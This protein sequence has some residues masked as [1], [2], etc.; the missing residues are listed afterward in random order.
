MCINI[1][2]NYTRISDSGSIKFSDLF[3]VRTFS[4]RSSLSDS[5][6]FSERFLFLHKFYG[7]ENSIEILCPIN[8]FFSIFTFFKGSAVLLSKTIQEYCK[9]P[10]QQH[11]C[12]CKN[13]Q[14]IFHLIRKRRHTQKPVFHFFSSTKKD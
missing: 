3:I 1:I 7:T 10:C 12:N 5:K 14:I 8:T 4:T 13:Q 6:L 9:F 2:P 11:R